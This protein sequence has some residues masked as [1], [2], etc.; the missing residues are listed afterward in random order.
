MEPQDTT[1]YP[2]GSWQSRID[3]SYEPAC[4]ADTCAPLM[5]SARIVECVRDLLV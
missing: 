1:N 3:R 2:V 4:E 5:L